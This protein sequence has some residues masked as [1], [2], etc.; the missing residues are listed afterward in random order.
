MLQRSGDRCVAV[1]ALM[2]VL[3]NV[4]RSNKLTTNKRGHRAAVATVTLDMDGKKESRG[5]GCN[6]IEV[7]QLP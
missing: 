1:A 4:H 7:L 5:S 6:R 3:G 2:N